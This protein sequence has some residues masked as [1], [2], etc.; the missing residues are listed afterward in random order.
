MKL[1]VV[2]AVVSSFLLVP[3]PGR[4]DESQRDLNNGYSLLHHL[5]EQEKQVDMIL[6]VKTTPP[7]V[8][9][10]LHEVSKSAGVTL[11][12]L[13]QMADRDPAIRFND[14]GLP[15][16]ETQTRASIKDDKQ[17]MLLFGTRDADFAKTILITQVEAGT[18]GMNM[19]KVLADAEPDGRRAAE[20]SH[21]SSRWEKLRNKAYA[22]IYGM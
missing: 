5:C 13:D 9:A 12:A 16:I 4:A 20:L 18:Y 3:R 10:F 14:Q 8:A 6:I 21:I 17:H 2:G 7:K 15:P 19:A 1:L 22:L 11:D